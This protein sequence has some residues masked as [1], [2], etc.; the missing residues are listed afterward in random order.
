[1][2]QSFEIL[3]H[4]PSQKVKFRLVTIPAYI[5]ADEVSVAPDTVA[6]IT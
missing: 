3:G 1:M 5:E 4:T 6:V 2:V